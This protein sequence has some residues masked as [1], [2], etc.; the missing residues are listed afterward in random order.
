MCCI[1]L[2]AQGQAS[3]P[4]PCGSLDMSAIRRCMG[5]MAQS[6]NT[7]GSR[8]Q[9]R[10]TFQGSQT[11]SLC[12]N[13]AA[14]LAGTRS[15]SLKPRRPLIGGSN[16]VCGRG[17]VRGGGGYD[18]IQVPPGAGEHETRHL[19]L[20]R[21]YQPPQGTAS[22]RGRSATF[23]RY[24]V[25]GNKPCP[26]THSALQSLLVSPFPA[27]S[28][29]GITS[30]FQRHCSTCSRSVSQPF[31]GREAGRAAND[32][33][34]SMDAGPAPVQPCPR[35]SLRTSVSRTCGVHVQELPRLGCTG[36]WAQWSLAR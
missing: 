14:P 19:R 26:L 23:S 29:A 11:R 32:A 3:N 30:T 10:K 2:V 36:N 24:S 4:T 21:L 25:G 34:K 33:A 5:A 35:R 8:G 27:P 22:P 6:L 16:A 9:G 18:A 15:I 20:T 1:S 12:I 31:T 17:A 28:T 7:H 13:S